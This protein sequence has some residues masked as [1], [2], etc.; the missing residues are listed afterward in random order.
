MKMKTLN[1]TI[2]RS[3]GEKIFDI[4]NVCF[5]VLMMIICIYPFWY[6]ICASFSKASL[7]MG[8]PGI[9]FRPWDSQRRLIGKFSLIPEYGLDMLILYF[10]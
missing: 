6:V 2:R 10:M 8:H 4:F 5:M 3:S 9:L 7:L 1:R